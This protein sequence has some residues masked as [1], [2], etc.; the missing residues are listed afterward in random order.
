[1]LEAMKTEVASNDLITLVRASDLKSKGQIA[2]RLTIFADD[3]RATG[4]SLHSL[5]TK[6]N[7]AVDS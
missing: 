7:E 3:A 1:M 6:I 4:E 2:E 5:G